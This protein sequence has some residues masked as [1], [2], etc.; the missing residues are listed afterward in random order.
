MNSGNH[1]DQA[2]QAGQAG[3]E[4]AVPALVSL[5]GLLR[6]DRA[7][8]DRLMAGFV[9]IYDAA[10]PIASEREDPAEWPARMSDARPANEPWMD[11]VVLVAGDGEAVLGG[12]AFEYYPQSRCGLLTYIAIDPAA[13]GHGLARPLA[14]R[15]LA[16]LRDAAHAHGAALAA[17][18]AEAERPERLDPA[19]P[20]AV[21]TA[22]RRL[23]ILA[24]L[25]A[26][27][28]QV[29]YVQ[30]ELPGGDGR[31]DHLML[32]RLDH[33]AAPLDTAALRAF[34]V[35]FYRALGVAD[36]ENDS[37][38]K[39]CLLE[40]GPDVPAVRLEAPLLEFH[41][42]AV[43]LH[44][45]SHEPRSAEP[46]LHRMCPIFGSMEGDLLS[47]AFQESRPFLSHCI[48]HGD[49]DAPPDS[50]KL[51]IEILFPTVLEYRSE[52]RR[53]AIAC[54]APQRRVRGYL[55][56]TRYE[57]AGR[58]VWHLTLRPAEGDWF[59]EYDLIKLIHLYDG[60]TED[61]QLHRKI[62]F[63]V[64]GAEVGTVEGLVPAAVR[65]L[66]GVDITGEVGG[67]GLDGPMRTGG[68]GHRG[69]RPVAGTI[70]L[71]ESA[72]DPRSLT[73][74]IAA[75]RGGEVGDWAGRQAG[76]LRAA[77]GVVTG[78]FDFEEIDLA[79]AEDTLTATL[80]RDDAFTRI[81]RRTLFHVT[82]ADRALEATAGTVGISPYLLV[83]HAVIVLNE[84]LLR[85]AGAR[86]TEVLGDGKVRLPELE[87]ARELVDRNLKG[88]WLPNVFHYDTEREL[89]RLG[90]SGRGADD[91]RDALK[92]RLEEIDSR[93]ED[94]WQHRRDMSQ[95]IIAV[96]LAMVSL[97]QIYQ[98]VV[99]TI[100]LF[101]D[102]SPEA[103]A[104][105][106]RGLKFAA[107]TFGFAAL[108]VLLWMLGIRR[109][110]AGRED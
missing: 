8:F 11:L 91:Q 87:T 49:E 5:R 43:C 17:A 56:R 73:A 75:M 65:Q 86:A 54:G 68:S 97:V 28:L 88:L 22:R 18:L 81:H 93:L 99:D 82:E 16:G 35:E 100:D 23:A 92:L 74:A 29:D 106:W 38:L 59:D 57:A 52:G 84:D 46:A 103:S 58:T 102:D 51:D 79:E 108:M 95:M 10:F 4:Q 7:R 101:A 61:T 85:E 12:V 78:I 6:A 66:V 27:R 60:V 76:L 44:A 30:P 20:D 1:P 24:R 36:P 3:A 70:E 15:A 67:A 33:D 83:P 64:E 89:Y 96:L 110:K 34:L 77:C 32:L 50:V 109:R 41:D 48:T 42:A 37:D 98:P 9:P 62:R 47:Y 19:D 26:R 2:G 63:R 105:L 25:G 21:R 80:E 13:R 69:T 71:V 72:E 90:L 94:A 39:A 14:E 53:E 31:A 45:V 55:N 107:F 104:A 40:C